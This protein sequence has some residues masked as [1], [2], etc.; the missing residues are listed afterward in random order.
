MGVGFGL[1]LCF[2]GMV[3]CEW[4]GI[5]YI[6]VFLYKGWCVSVVY[7]CMLRGGYV[8][9]GGAVRVSL[10]LYMCVLVGVEKMGVWF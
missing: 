5:V 7:V 4:R 3:E 10:F 8:G 2:R 6:W 9:M 1:F